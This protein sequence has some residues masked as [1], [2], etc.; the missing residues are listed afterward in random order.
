V[1]PA[2]VA[3]QPVLA[4]VASTAASASASAPDPTAAEAPSARPRPAVHGTGRGMKKAPG[5]DPKLP[6]GNPY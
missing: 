4:T 1:A 6:F 2:V 3:P 5:T